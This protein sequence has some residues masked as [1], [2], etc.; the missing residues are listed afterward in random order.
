MSPALAGR[1]FPTVSSGKT[2]LENDNSS[3]F[4]TFFFFF[5]SVVLLKIV[6]CKICKI[7]NLTIKIKIV[8]FLWC[9]LETLSI[10]KTNQ[11]WV[12][13]TWEENST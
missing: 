1:F 13:F 4:L 3:C 11:S 5:F 12:E 10:T 8:S 6:N 2:D 9:F 7:Y